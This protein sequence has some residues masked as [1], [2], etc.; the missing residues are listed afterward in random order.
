MLNP[1]LKKAAKL[2]VLVTLSAGMVACANQDMY[3]G[4][5]YGGNLAKAELAVTYGTILSVK[6]VT[7]QA[8]N[9]STNIIGGLGGAVLGGL[10]GS[11]IG[12]GKGQ[13]IAGTV[14]AIAGGALGNSAANKLNRVQA[15]QLIIRKDNGQTV[16]VVQKAD[17]AFVAG[18]RV[19]LVGSNPVNVNPI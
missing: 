3:S 9:G 6:P 1:L 15:M 17:P 13:M 4:S 11:T 12:G 14:G 7:I 18:R 19:S 16:V 10:L 5:T 8:G 2:A